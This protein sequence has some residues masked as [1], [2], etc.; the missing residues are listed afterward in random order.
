MSQEHWWILK[1]RR[2]QKNPKNSALLSL[3]FQTLLP[4]LF[5]NGAYGTTTIVLY[6]LK[7]DLYIIFKQLLQIYPIG[8]EK[9]I[10]MILF[11][12]ILSEKLR[13]PKIEKSSLK[14]EK[15]DFY[16][17]SKNFFRII[18]EKMLPARLNLNWGINGGQDFLS[19]AIDG[20]S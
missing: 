20:A 10:D 2:R 4:C 8:V 18:I 11:W 1:S 13:I 15:V 3:Y 14:N 7:S 5:F 12:K 9:K 16:C 6:A 19:T 17:I